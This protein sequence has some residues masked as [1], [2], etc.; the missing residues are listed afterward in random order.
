MFNYDEKDINKLETYLEY[1]DYE[2]NSN[3]ISVYH[4]PT[5]YYYKNRIAILFQENNNITIKDYT[6]NRKFEFE[7]SPNEEIIINFLQYLEKNLILA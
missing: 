2:L 5:C 3:K 7:S 4:N 1:N 6:N